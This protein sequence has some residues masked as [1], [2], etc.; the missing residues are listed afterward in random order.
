MLRTFVSNGLNKI[1][2]NQLFKGALSGPK[3][4]LAAAGMGLGGVAGYY[5]YADRFGGGAGVLIGLAE[6]AGL[7][8]VGGMA[9][10]TAG[11]TAK[12]LFTGGLRGAVVG[13]AAPAALMAGTLAP[14]A[15]G[16]AALIHGHKFHKRRR[17]INMAKRIHDRSGALADTRMLAIRKL[18]RD[19][20]NLNRSFGNEAMRFHR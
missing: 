4:A 10:R 20:Y 16:G 5:A 15:I 12:G 6:G 2:Q 19:R 17:E 1:T 14:L 13:G 11:G 9:L 18:G 8:F 3:G 7:D